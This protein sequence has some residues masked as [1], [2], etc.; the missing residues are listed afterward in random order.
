MTLIS[1]AD[2][3]AVSETWLT[4]NDTAILSDITPQGYKLHHCPRSDRRGGGTALI[5][6]ESINVE[7][8][9]VAG[10]GSFEASE[11]LV[12]PAATTRLRVVIVYRPPY[13]V[14][15]PVSTSTFITEFSDYLESLVMS[16]E[17][18][19]I[20]GDFNIHMDLPDDTDCRNMSD[21]LVSMGLKQHVLQ[22]THELGH[23]LDLIITRISDNIIAGRPYTGELF[24]DHFPVFCQLK[25]E[26]PLVAVKHLQFR[27]IKSIDRDQFSEAICSS[28]LC[29]EPPDDL[30][31][32]V[33]CYNE[34]L[35]SVLD[36]YAPV[37]SRDI[38]VRPRAPWFNED[39][40]K[41]K[42]TRR[43]AEKK[44]RTTRLPADLAAFKKERNCVVNLMNEARRVYYNQFI[45]DNSTD[46]RKLFMA[47]KSLLNM[48][49][50]RS[51]P[52]HIDVSLLA[53]DMGEFFITKI[54]NIRSKLDGISPSHLPSTS[55]P[56]LVSE[57][58]DIV[59][60]DFQCQTVEAIR[61]MITSGKKKSCILDP[62]PVTLLS[63]CLDPLLPVITNM[64]NLSL[65]TG[66][67]ADAWKTAVVHPLLKKPGL[68]LLFKN[69]RPI[70]NLQFVS[71][72]TERVV[73]NQIQCHMIKNNLFPQL[74]SAYRSHHST[75]T[76][77]LKVKNDLLM[78]MNKGHVSLLVL[79]DLSAAFDT[80][81]H[82][83]LLKTLQMKLGVCGS[84]LSWFK[85]YL[86]GRSQRIC[87][88]ETLSQ[89]FD[90]KWGVPQGSCL[91]PLLFTIYS[92]DLFSLLESHLPTAHAY[93]DDT[94]LYLSFS[95]S[96]GT[97]ELDAVTAIENCIRDIRQ[98]MCVRKLML[99][100]DKTEFLIVGTRKQL[101]K[102]SIDGV[103]VGDYNI[104][105]SPSVRNLGTWFDSHLDMDVHITKTCS[106]AFY[107][108]YNI[109]HIRKYLSR[110]STE[111]LIHA[112]IT[113][114]LDY[115]NSLL[116]GLPKY[117]LSKLQRVMNASARLVYCAPKS[118]HITPLLRE[119]HWLPVCYR[120]EY[121]IILLTF[122]VLHGM[123]PDYLRHLISV[124]PPSRYNLRRNDDSAA[125]LTFP[126][127]RTKKTLADRSFSCAAPRL[128]NLL[129]TTIRSTSSLDIFKIRLKTFLF[130]RA[131]N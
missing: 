1:K 4:D 109:R 84:A 115:C 68:D 80:V 50:D 3:F 12:N 32:L 39:I 108:L 113:S 65:R 44:W 2:L 89:S 42:R 17:P 98:W 79:L 66:Y 69:F 35:R 48:Q 64:V 92:S 107:Y 94:Q 25:P 6:K 78:N 38:I 22:P 11:W 126:T 28:Q 120:I 19:L 56:D 61:D 106:S 105:P 52:P 67:F 27:K 51:L 82:K 121:K 31:T 58:S 128:W 10:K 46:Q 23:T 76:A 30:D 119:L 36:I 75:E 62:I 74:Q 59:L 40:R 60:S 123:A 70:S 13:S 95:P 54:A 111:T 125:L 104:S 116:Y 124:L 5:F 9:S 18:L 21:L 130:N 127:I 96:D 122:K 81:D 129:P 7:K 8:V 85:S 57:P 112:F 114:R 71:K 83:I 29:L 63:A 88:K 33:N 86:E 45:E 101:T 49:P 53:N 97:G 117:Q 102:V 47:S 20:L 87:I 131:F 90:L 15:H 41:A 55:E 110:S 77:L 37:L 34:T 43:R 118:C 93:A 73:A 24:S 26:R 72:L 100:D 103:R 14:K 16:S 99:N 91:G